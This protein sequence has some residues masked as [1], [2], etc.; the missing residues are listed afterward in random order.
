MWKTYND[1]INE[2]NNVSKSF[3][4]IYKNNNKTDYYNYIVLKGEE[5]YNVRIRA[6][7]KM[8]YK[9]V[10]KIDK[11]I[12]SINGSLVK[13][14]SEKMIVILQKNIKIKNWIYLI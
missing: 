6:G 12:Y 10:G 4:Q 14:P 11:K 1:F 8:I 3:L 7:E 5:L 2:E 13:T 9:Y